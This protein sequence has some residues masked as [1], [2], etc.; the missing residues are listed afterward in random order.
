M[1]MRSCLRTET[2]AALLLSG[3]AETLDQLDITERDGGEV[4]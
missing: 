1:M 2:D 3:E 4:R